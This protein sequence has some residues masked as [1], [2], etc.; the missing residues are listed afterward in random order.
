MA[1]TIFEYL[2]MNEKY[3]IIKKIPVL[4][5]WYQKFIGV[6]STDTALRYNFFL[7]V[8]EIQFFFNQ[9]NFKS[10]FEFEIKN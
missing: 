10:E 8:S 6:V 7:K 9:I 5:R 4:S 2:K 1:D 3:I